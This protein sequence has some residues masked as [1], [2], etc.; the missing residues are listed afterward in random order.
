MMVCPYD[1]K[2]LLLILQVGSETAV[3]LAA[4]IAAVEGVDV[5]FL[6]V[7]D[8]AGSIGLLRDGAIE[9]LRAVE[10]LWPAG[11]RA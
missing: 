1:E 5:P 4:E 2:R 6:G 10:L 9:G 3:C 8:M 11:A 7:N